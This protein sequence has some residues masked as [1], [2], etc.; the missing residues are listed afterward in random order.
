MS[1]FQLSVIVAS[2]EVGPPTQPVE[3]AG[4]ANVRSLA[5]ID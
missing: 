3:R 2:V 1:R 5:Q 4:V